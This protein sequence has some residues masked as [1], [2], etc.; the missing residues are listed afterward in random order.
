MI[1]SSFHPFTLH[2]VRPKIKHLGIDLAAAKVFKCLYDNAKRKF[3]RAFNAILGKLG[4]LPQ[5]RL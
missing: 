3:Y 1:Q 2:F 4:V 5:S